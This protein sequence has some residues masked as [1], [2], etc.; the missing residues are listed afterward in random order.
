MKVLHIPYT[1][2]PDPVGGTEVYV[3]DLT[4][5]LLRFGIESIVAAPSAAGGGRE[6]VHDGVRVSRLPVTRDAAG[7]RYVYGAGDPIARAAVLELVRRHAVDVVHFHSYTPAIN[8][9][10]ARAV[11]D[12]GAGVVVTYHTPTVTCQRGNLLLFG[13]GPCDG[14]MLVR[15]CSACVLQQ[16]GVPRPA[17]HA[18]ARVPPRA[19]RALQAMGMGGG[20]WSALQTPELMRLR[21]E[22]TREFLGAAHAVVAVTDW[23]RDVLLRNGVDPAKISFSR[24]GIGSARLDSP[25]RATPGT[26]PRAGLRAIMLGRL[27]P[28][29]G[30]DV[31]LQALARR[32]GMQITID[33]FGDSDTDS[34][35]ARAL[36]ATAAA[37]PRVSLRPPLPPSEV[38]ARIAQYDV[39][40]V[41][42]R[43]LE[44]GPL[45]VLEAQAANVPVVGSALGGIAERVRHDVDGML[46][47]TLSV[48]A[49]ERAL[50]E[51]DRDPTRLDRW[52]GAILPPRTM[53]AVAEDMNDVYRNVMLKRACA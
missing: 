14:T 24:Q 35:Y 38:I 7:L 4:A 12:A 26:R 44:S 20:V 27:D 2:H 18:L 17:A 28:L 22:D 23:V 49:W 43:G 53:A 33:I 34:E 21:H 1:Y 50:V 25:P 39:L 45:V 8:G 36:R 41:P 40:L 29:K 30:F 3:A 11:R 10:V 31:P 15:R 9:I 48:D 47:E 51:L 37:D 19:G 52:R 6:Y 42:S 46:V 13:G 5:E 16:F 32:P